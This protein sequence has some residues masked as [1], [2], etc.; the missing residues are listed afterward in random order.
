MKKMDKICV[1]GINQLDY[2]YM[3]KPELLSP[4]QDMVSLR[5][6]IEAGCDAVYFGVK[7]FNMREG[8]KNFGVDDLKEIAKV[9]HENK[10]RA[11]LAVNTIVFDDEYAKIK[12]ILKKAK[13]AKIDAII[14]W[15]MF[16]LEEAK[17]L[18]LEIHLSTQASVA[19]S[20]AAE[21]FRKKGVKRIVMA[22]ECSL[23]QIKKIKERTSSAKASAVEVEIFIHGAMCVAISG[24]CFMSQFLYGK[25]ANRG[26]CLQ[27][28]RREYEITEI[29]R[30]GQFVIGQDYVMSPKDLCA[31]P[32]IEKLLEAGVDG[33]KIEGRNRSPEYVFAVTKAYREVVDYYWK[34]MKA[35]K[36]KNIKA[37]KQILIEF[38]ELKK[39]GMEE[40]KKVYNRGFGDGFYMGKPINEWALSYGSQATEKKIHVGKVNHVYTKIGVAE[41]KIEAK[42]R[43]KS[44]DELIFQGPWTGLYRQKISSMEIEHA[45][46]KKA[47][48]GDLVAIKLNKMVKAN[49][50]VYKVVNGDQ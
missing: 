37:K 7:G 33:L 1:I 45:Q 42:V 21:F 13:M 11:F 29:D 35:L 17:K 5:A 27:P 2:Y 38:D 6:A 4:I 14:C 20:Q 25:S 24:R 8:A 12:K 26:A 16:V 39:Q 18:G 34:N 31:L 9:C 28:C 10:V 36:Q 46:V 19:N 43:I 47:T 48:Q 3:K 50:Q 22:R 41:I 44:G 23:E 15:D 30:D 49:D 40:L 32:F